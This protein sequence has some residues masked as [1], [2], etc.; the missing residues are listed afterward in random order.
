M[1]RRWTHVL[2]DMDGTILESADAVMG[3]IARTLIEYG[4][5]VPGR[6]ELQLL[7]GPP[8]HDI[9]G[10]Y[11]P[12]EAVP[13][14]S[15]FYRG[16]AEADG[17]NGYELFV[18]LR[19]LI[20]DLHSA[21][22][23]VATA[24]T[25]LR[26]EAARVVNYFEIGQYFAVIQGADPDHGV[27]DKGNV[28]AACLKDLGITSTD[29]P[30]MIGDRIFDIHGAARCGVPTI[31]CGWGYAAPEEFD[32]AYARVNTAAELREELLR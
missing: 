17:M 10:K 16:L 15:A 1:T 20:V 2:F 4:V 31:M 25:K 32:A 18:G 3:R 13:E 14:A 26:V 28:V 23:P 24:T 8:T 30:I 7:L 21:G 5:S 11:L 19:D 22:I 6:T 27:H 29:R 12:S 9:L